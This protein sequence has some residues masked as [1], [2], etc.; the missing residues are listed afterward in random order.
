MASTASGSF[1]VPLLTV[2]TGTIMGANSSLGNWRTEVMVMRPG[3]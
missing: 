2:G 1:S 3:S